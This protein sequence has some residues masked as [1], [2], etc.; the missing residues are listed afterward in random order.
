M[1]SLFSEKCPNA[2]LAFGHVKK[3]HD[4]VN[5]T[6]EYGERNNI[7]YNNKKSSHINIELEKKWERTKITNPFLI[8][9]TIISGVSFKY[10]MVSIVKTK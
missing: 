1:L 6:E 4:L 9:Q 8:S 7:T 2:I 5:M 3:G 10:D